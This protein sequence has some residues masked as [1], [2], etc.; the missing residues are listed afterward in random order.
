MN[1]DAEALAKQLSRQLADRGKLIEAGWVLFW[2][3]IAPDGASRVQKDE[4]R[5]AFFAGA[6]HLFGSMVSIMDDEREP[7]EADLKRMDNIAAELGEYL[8][9]LK[10]T[11]R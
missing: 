11:M 1:A 4:T 6:Q 9:E 2:A 10:R 5:K 7:T 8:A 3:L